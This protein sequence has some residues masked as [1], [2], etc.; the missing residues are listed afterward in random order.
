MPLTSQKS[1]V[2]VVARFRPLNSMELKIDTLYR[3]RASTQDNDNL[4]DPKKVKL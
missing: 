1:Q 4:D 2:M 3:E